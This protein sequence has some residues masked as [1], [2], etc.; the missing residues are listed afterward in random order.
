MVLFGSF[1]CYIFIWSFIQESFMIDGEQTGLREDWTICDER[2]WMTQL[3]CSNYFVRRIYYCSCVDRHLLQNQHLRHI[4]TLQQDCYY[5]NTRFYVVGNKQSDDI[6][7]QRTMNGYGSY[8][9]L[10]NSNCKFV[11][12]LAGSFL[13]WCGLIDWPVTADNYR[14][15]KRFKVWIDSMVLPI[16]KRP[17]TC[18]LLCSRVGK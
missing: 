12:L 8:V 14:P 16:T 3:Q 13:A 5:G 6:E 1:D 2:K 18:F 17:G 9:W 10:I 15:T 11:M 4:N 7:R